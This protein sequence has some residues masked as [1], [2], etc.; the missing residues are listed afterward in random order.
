MVL[1][2]DKVV[3]NRAKLGPARLIKRER[4]HQREESGTPNPLQND[5][6]K[7]TRRLLRRTDE[8]NKIFTCLI[9]IDGHIL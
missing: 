1:A 7:Q 9:N 8:G 4:L 6:F 3:K 2:E 5:A